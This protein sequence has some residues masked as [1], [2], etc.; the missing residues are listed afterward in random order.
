MANPH[1]DLGPDRGSPPGTPRWVK[2]F[3]IVG[4]VLVLLVVVMMATG[5]GGKHGPGRHMPSAGQR[6]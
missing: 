5:V 3:G 2:V 4:L 1:P 6:P